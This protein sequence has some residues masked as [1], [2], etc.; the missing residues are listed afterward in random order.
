MKA[1]E[2]TAIVKKEDLAGLIRVANEVNDKGSLRI[3]KKKIKY[4]ALDPTHVY[5]A[6]YE[7]KAEGTKADRRDKGIGINM[8]ALWGAIRFLG[9][10]EV[11]IKYIDNSQL[12]THPTWEIRTKNA[13]RWMPTIEKMPLPKIR[14]PRLTHVFSV[15]TKQLK[16]AIKMLGS[17]ST[18]KICI[19]SANDGTVVLS[20]QDETRTDGG[21][22]VLS[23]K[24]KQRGVKNFVSHYSL[25]ILM[26]CLEKI[27][28][29]TVEISIATDSPII[30][31]H[32]HGV[33]AIAP[34]VED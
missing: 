24:W 9:G 30:I 17:V 26:N 7:I 20:N 3:M 31:R 28:D 19:E 25:G 13:A 8:T 34:K 11:S 12:Y 27:K 15:N 21:E 5:F 2:K 1:I 16:R 29:K 18:D 14:I 6:S 32:E 23:V 33:F 22:V 10:G 4:A